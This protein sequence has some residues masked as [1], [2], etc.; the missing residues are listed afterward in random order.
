MILSVKNYSA[1]LIIGSVMISCISS[2]NIQRKYNYQECAKN[3][4]NDFAEVS[5]GLFRVPLKGDTLLLTQVIFKCT[6]SASY[7]LR[8]MYGYFGKWN[9]HTVTNNSPKPLLIWYDIDLF[10][11]GNKY[12]I[13]TF[14]DEVSKHNIFTSFM[15]FNENHEDLL[16]DNAFKNKCQVF[17]ANNI[18]F[19]KN[20]SS[21]FFED[22][23]KDFLPKYWEKYKKDKKIN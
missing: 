20:K 2:S 4:K 16:L 7:N 8:T 23:L 21:D 11:E 13:I 12:N 10:S 5:E 1:L 3:Y 6:S 22:Y 15:I 14:G 9:S 17:F 18:R 19:N